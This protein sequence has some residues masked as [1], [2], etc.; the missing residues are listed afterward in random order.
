MPSTRLTAANAD[1]SLVEHLASGGPWVVPILLFALFATAVAVGKGV[2]LYRLPALAPA[3]AERVEAA[4]KAGSTS[5][6]NLVGQMR[7][8]QAELLQ[9]ALATPD[10]EQRDERLYA[11]LLR[12][13]NKLES[14]LGA[15]AMTASVAPLLGLLGTVSGMITTFKDMTLSGAG[16]AGA[17][18][19]GISVALVT[20]QMGLVVAVPALLAHALMSRKVKSYFAQLEND[21]VHLSQLPFPARAP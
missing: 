9:I 1:L 17:V 14:W 20:T 21:A 11:A 6:Q 8:P 18:S 4:L 5:L 10:A 13:R 12:Q 7:G 19:A 3:L 2:W 15:I 16:D